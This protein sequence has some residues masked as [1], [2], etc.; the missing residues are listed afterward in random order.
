[1]TPAS[2]FVSDVWPL[3]EKEMEVD[4]VSHVEGTLRSKSQMLIRRRGFVLGLDKH[5]VSSLRQ[6]VCIGIEMCCRVRVVM[7]CRGC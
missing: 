5:W 1:M 4:R 2:Q 7:Y 6:S 3:Q